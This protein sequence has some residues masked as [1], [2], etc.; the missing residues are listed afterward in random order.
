L[1]GLKI[2]SDSADTFY[3]NISTG[4]SAINLNRAGESSSVS[5]KSYIWPKYH[6]GKVDKITYPGPRDGEPVYSKPTL[7]EKEKL[8]GMMYRS[9]NEYDSYG[10]TDSRKPFI[11]PGSFFDALA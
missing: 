9:E 3:M 8:I 2:S 11:K 6:D 10:R 4:I 7:A 5:S 1:S